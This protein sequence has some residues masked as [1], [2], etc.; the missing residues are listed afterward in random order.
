MNISIDLEQQQFL[1]TN[2][3]TGHQAEAAEHTLCI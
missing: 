2:V 1:G 3:V